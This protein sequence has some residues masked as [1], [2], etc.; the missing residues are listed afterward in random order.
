M[1]RL[2]FVLI[3]ALV[4]LLVGVTPASATLY[5]QVYIGVGCFAGNFDYADEDVGIYDDIRPV[6]WVVRL[7]T[8][9]VPGVAVEARYIS[10][11]GEES[12]SDGEGG[13]TD[14]DLSATLGLIKANLPKTG[15]AQ[16]YGLLGWSWVHIET[17]DMSDK[18]DGVAFGA[19]VE[20]DVTKNTFASV[21]FNHIAN[22]ES[23]DVSGLTILFNGRF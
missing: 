17:P 7:G 2:A 14:F 19:G 3:T 12:A 22:V 23:C 8:Y 4:L 15:K 13:K 21:E 5:G 16:L 20:V 6:G 9:L 18:F 10:A 11:S 1:K